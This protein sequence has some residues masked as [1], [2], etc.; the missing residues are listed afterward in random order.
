MAHL[1]RR[2]FLATGAAGLPLLAGLPSPARPGPAVQPG[3]RP[4]VVSSANGLAAVT[5]AMRRLRGGEPP[6]DAVVAGVSL[7]EDDPEDMSVGLGGLPNEEGVV[8]L[9]ASVMDGPSHKAGAVAALRNIRNPSQVALRVLRRTDHVLLVGEG[10]LKFAR[11]HGFKE[12]N[13]LT[14]RAR[15]AWLR[16]KEELSADDDWLNREQHVPAGRRSASAAE[17]VPTTM[18]TIHCAAVNEAG[19]LGAC[20]TTSGLSYKIPGRVGDSPIVG[21]GMFVDNAVGAAGATGRGESVIQSCGAFQVVR[22]MAEGVEPTEACLRVLRFIAEH[23]RRPDLLN[24]RG[25]PNFGVVLYALRKDG[26]TGGAAMRGGQRY[27]IHDG[28]E[29]RLLECARLFP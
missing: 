26:V 28:T 10:A 25:E 6:V 24:E 1:D 19:D 22:H 5:E 3:R 20:T 7:V 17:P 23:T 27:A 21:A 15:E 12:E 9:D 14:E 2:A 29:A 18:G 8:E 4:C 11:A 16:W 13:L